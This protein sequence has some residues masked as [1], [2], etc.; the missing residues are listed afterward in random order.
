MKSP[1]G[2]ALFFDT[3]TWKMFE[4]VANQSEQSAEHMILRAVIGR[5]G[6]IHQDNFVLN[7]I[8]RGHI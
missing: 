6:E 7:R 8:M 3:P 5:L 4:E 1:D 2:I